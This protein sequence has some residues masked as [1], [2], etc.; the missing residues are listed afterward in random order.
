MG[1]GFSALGSNTTASNSTGVGNNA[2]VISTGASNTFLGSGSDVGT[3]T[4]TNAA[5]IGANAIASASNRMQLGDSAVTVD[6]FGFEMT[7]TTR[8]LILPRMTTTQRDAISTPVAGEIIYN[9]T[10][11]VLDFYDG[12]VWAPV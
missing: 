3:A 4:F 9:T 10:T 11:T 5:A 6:V 1:I 12:T 2:G 7:S 8:G